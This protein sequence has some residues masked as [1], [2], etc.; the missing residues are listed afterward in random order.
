MEAEDTVKQIAENL[1][2]NPA[3]VVQKSAS[4]VEELKDTR[5]ELEDFKKAA[6]GSEVDDMVKDA[7]E[8]GGV[9]LVT[10]EFKDYNIN[11]L[12]NLSDDIKAQHK[13]IVMVFAT[14][15]GPKVTFLVS[16]TDDLLEKGLHAGNMIKQ[17]AAACGGGG[18]G[19]ADMAQ[20]GAKDSTKI[21]AAFKVAEELLS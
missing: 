10:K 6:M 18:G 17:I 9:K 11:D 1:K 5:K 7:K 21:S 2:T 14:V 20:A 4:I 8:I 3:A 13:G 15:N 12:R 19:K 16:I